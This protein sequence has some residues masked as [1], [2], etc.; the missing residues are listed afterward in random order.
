MR[1]ISITDR[2]ISLE[3]RA[4]DRAMS[5]QRRN[6]DYR[7]PL[8]LVAPSW[9]H[10]E[11]NVAHRDTSHLT[12]DLGLSLVAIGWLVG[13]GAAL[14]FVHCLL[15]GCNH[16]GPEL[17]AL[18]SGLMLAGAGYSIIDAARLN[19]ALAPYRNELERI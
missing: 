4:V 9:A 18:A 3:R 6:G 10:T 1:N 2:R 8:G 5:A 15:T 11:R 17:I 13:L 7:Q 14:A 19:A 16:F 12:V